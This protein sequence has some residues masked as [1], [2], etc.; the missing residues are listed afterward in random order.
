MCPLGRTKKAANI[1][2]LLNKPNKGFLLD[3]A[4]FVFDV[5]ARNRVIF[6]N[7]HLFGHGGGNTL[8][9]YPIASNDVFVAKPYTQIDGDEKFDDLVYWLSENVLYTRMLQA[10]VLP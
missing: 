9:N 8:F 10:G 3:L 6:P 5:L 2:S 1:R 7:R 4:F